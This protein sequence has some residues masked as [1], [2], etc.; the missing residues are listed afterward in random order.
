MNEALAAVPESP[1]TPSSRK[2]SLL[3]PS[4]RTPLSSPRGGSPRGGSPRERE[5]GGK[6]NKTFVADGDDAASADN[7]QL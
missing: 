4:T 6:V 2:M 5:K 3:T 1:V 7:G